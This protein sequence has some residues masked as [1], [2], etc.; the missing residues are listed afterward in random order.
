MPPAVAAVGAV[1]GALTSHF[2]AAAV[3]G[4]VLGAVVGAVAG[5]IVSTGIS[6]LGSKVFGKEPDK[7]R[8]ESTLLSADVK[9]GGRTQMV[10][11]P[12]TSHRIIYGRTRVSGPIVFIHSRPVDGSSEKL[13]MLHVVIVLAAHESN[14]IQDIFFNDE[15]LALDGSGNATADPY[16]Q[17]STVYANVYKHLGSPDQLADS[18]LVANSAGKWSDGHRLRGLTYV[19]AMLRFDE[20]AYASGLPNISA[21]VKGREVYDP[22]TE[23]TAWSENA[24]LCILDYLLS[25]FGLNASLDEIDLNSFISAANICDETVDTLDGEE[26]R[27]TCNGVVD[28][29]SK[30][31][32]ILEDM[33]TSCA[34]FLAY[35]GGKWRL[36]VGAFDAPVLTIE[37]KHAR[38]ALLLKPHR[39]RYRLVNTIRGAF[40]SPEHQW[41]PTEFPPVSREV[42]VAQDGDEEVAS[43]LDLP[44]TQS[45]TMAQRIA[46]I[47]LEKNRRQKQILFPANLIG[48][49]VA[50]GNTIAIDWPRMGLAGLPC[51]VTSWLMTENLGVDLTLDEDGADVYA[52]SPT[53]LTPLENA[54]AVVAPNNVAVPPTAPNG[55]NITA[56]ADYFHIIWNR[57]PDQDLRYVELW[58]HTDDTDDPEEDASRVLEVFGNEVT[59]NN[60]TGQQTLYYWVRSVDRYG[61]KSTFVGPISDTTS[62]DQ[63]ITLVLE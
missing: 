44:F 13:D 47:A 9:G 23:E 27:Y 25:S 43:T 45:H 5:G 11:Q 57:I 49:Q 16:K 55:L 56:G 39:S 24:A 28:L 30:P 34:G 7:P 50:A 60:L 26:K 18:V 19:H 32:D 52:F 63:P 29:A 12:I 41:Q 8:F 22:R 54:P 38:D 1:A 31:N 15:V 59:R 4:G 14:A 17:G 58:E 2:I 35:T 42:Y 36:K 37:P 51:Q 10:R 46:Y 48:F 62:G 6:F 33:L 53:D 61:N 3:G 20:K 40:V 21:V